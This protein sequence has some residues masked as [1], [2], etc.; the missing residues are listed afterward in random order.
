MQR[1][2]EFVAS[3]EAGGSTAIYSALAEAYRQASAAQAQE[4]DRY[5]SI[6]RAHLQTDPWLSM[7]AIIPFAPGPEAL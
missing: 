5:Y 3:L 2:R 7:S 6:A 1:I 4:P